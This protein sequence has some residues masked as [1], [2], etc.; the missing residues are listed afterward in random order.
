MAE[1][2]A[3]RVGHLKITDHLILGIT[4]MKQDK[5]LETF[6]HCTIDTAP[7]LGWNMV[8][9][10]LARGEVNA[11]FML[12]P[13]AMDLFKSGAP[14]RLVLFTHRTG[15]VLITNKRA[16]IKTLEDFRVKVVIIP[17]QLSVH[18]MLLHL[19]LAE[20]GLKPGSGKDP[21]VDVLLEVMAPSQM[22]EAI[23]YD[24]EGEVAGF[25][26]AEPYGSQA[27]IEGY[28]E[29]FA[30]SK[31]LWPNHPCCVCVVREELAEG[32]PDAV[33][34]LVNSLVASGVSV[35]ANPTAAATL[36][37]M[38]L[39]QKDEVLKRVLTQPADRIKTTELFP[40]I[41]DLATMQDYMHDHMTVLK[42]KID[43]EK[44]VDTSFARQAGAK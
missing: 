42:S 33:Q 4:K 7:Y 29:E 36:G 27:V 9:D 35:G 32:A 20:A 25:I 18:H 37:S 17:Y 11:A 34:E 13:T 1:K 38:F 43:L 15:S 5:G 19:M 12:A 16:G 6:N 30:L 22:P 28:G 21:G 23:Q 26:V 10:A 14:I 40:V 8:A 31:D 2:T 39:G 24:E 44:F 3:I 41:E